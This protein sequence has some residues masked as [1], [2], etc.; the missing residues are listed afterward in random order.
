MV[1]NGRNNHVPLFQPITTRLVFSHFWHWIY[2]FSGAFPTL[3]SFHRPYW[4]KRF[5]HSSVWLCWNSSKKIFCWKSYRDLDN[6]ECHKILIQRFFIIYPFPF[7]IKHNLVSACVKASLHL[8]C[9]FHVKNYFRCNP[10][11]VIQSSL[12]L[13]FLVTLLSGY[14]KTRIKSGSSSATNWSPSITAGLS[15]F[16]L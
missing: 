1:L 6:P 16:L 5:F 11:D 10:R 4:L 8:S 3:T 2:F 14:K 15:F 12:F 7:D 9:H 13:S